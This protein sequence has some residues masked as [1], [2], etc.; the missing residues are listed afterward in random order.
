M[1]RLVRKIDEGIES[2]AQGTN[3]EK[4]TGGMISKLE[5]AKKAGNYGIPTRLVKG[6]IKDVVPRLLDGEEIGTLFTAK[7]KLTRKKCWIAFAFKP[8]GKLTVDPGA[9]MALMARGKSLLPSGVTKVE[10]DFARGECVEVADTVD[11]LIARGI[12]NYSSSDILKI[13]GSKSVE[14]EKKL[15]YKYTEEVIHRDNMVLL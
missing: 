5:A 14:I 15:G 3:S 11:R 12:V 6:D 1:L 2:L 10:G 7:K 8:K 4:S 9:E 13:K